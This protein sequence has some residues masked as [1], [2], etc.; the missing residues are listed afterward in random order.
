MAENLW[1]L[2]LLDGWWL[3]RGDLDLKVSLRQQRLIAAL[4]LLGPRP[5]PYLAGT[6]W[7]DSADTQASGNLREAIW[8]ISRQLPGLLTQD[9]GRLELT[10]DVHIDV[11]E[12][13]RTISD[14]TASDD[15][16]RVEL[17]ARGE[18]LPGWYDDWVL[19]EQE[20]WRLQRLAALETMAEVMLTRGETLGTMEAAHAALRIEPLHANAI[21]L[22]L[23]VYME[24][25]NHAGAL[26]AYRDYSSRMRTEFG[27][28]LPAD[29]TEIIRPLLIK[30]G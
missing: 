9:N 12:L 11:Q 7:P 24:E 30:T 25:G 19:C 13:R 16:G 5:R 29:V 27:V 10:E 4:A 2:Q 6:L 21:R 23:R 1:K 20:R 14:T 28:A 15:R 3:R 18:L 22:I 8:T 26:D 17:L